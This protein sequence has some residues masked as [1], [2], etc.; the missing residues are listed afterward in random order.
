MNKRE[1]E[2]SIVKDLI[3]ACYEACKDREIAKKAIRSICLEFGGGQVYIPKNQNGKMA[4]V[5][6]FLF[7][8]ISNEKTANS[9]LE[10]VCTLLGGQ[11][12]Y[13]PLE[14]N[15]FKKEIAI[16]IYNEYDGT[17]DTMRRICKEKRISFTNLYR[18]YYLGGQLLRRREALK[19]VSKR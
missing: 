2:L 18:L 15:A 6:F 1:S 14:K 3:D 16:E 7:N 9:M 12:L 8:E 13:I 4:K 19:D 11:L 17:C 5:F 10:R